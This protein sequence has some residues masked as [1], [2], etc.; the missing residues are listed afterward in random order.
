MPEAQPLE[1]RC[2]VYP[3]LCSR[4]AKRADQAPGAIDVIN[5]ADAAKFRCLR[6]AG[7]VC[8]DIPAHKGEWGVGKML[9][10]PMRHRHKTAVV[11]AGHEEVPHH[12][13]AMIFGDEQV[14]LHNKVVAIDTCNA[15]GAGIVSEL[16][17]SE[18]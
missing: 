10:H 11:M 18:V 17:I 5:I 6:V 16:E 3:L 4:E 9:G 12:E 1:K 14:S 15:F 8:G 13:F 7:A 2:R